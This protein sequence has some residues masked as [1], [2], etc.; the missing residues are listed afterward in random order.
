M[1]IWYRVPVP[2]RYHSPRFWYRYQT[3]VFGTGTDTH[4]SHFLVLVLSVPNGYRA[5]P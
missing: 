2:N 4:F 5:H 3:G 1:S